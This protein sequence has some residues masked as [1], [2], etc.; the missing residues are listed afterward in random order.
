MVSVAYF[1]IAIFHFKAMMC[2][3]QHLN[4]FYYYRESK[5]KNFRKQNLLAGRRMIR[6]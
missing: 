2:K 3:V 5:L 4:D 6:I 1:T